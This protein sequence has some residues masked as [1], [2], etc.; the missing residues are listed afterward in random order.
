M[1][2]RPVVRSREQEHLVVS[3]CCNCGEFS[4][5]W[6]ALE[7]AG[8]AEVWGVTAGFGAYETCGLKLGK[9]A[10]IRR[11]SCLVIVSCLE[12]LIDFGKSVFPN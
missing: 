6:G 1:V 11:Q 5:G 4:I 3:V 7:S 2:V 9:R 8:T 10:H 12:V